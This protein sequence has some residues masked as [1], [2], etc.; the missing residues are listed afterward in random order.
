MPSLGTTRQ[1]RPGLP[2]DRE[3]VEQ[4]VVEWYVDSEAATE[5]YRNEPEFMARLLERGAIRHAV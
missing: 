3:A 4:L 2:G 1:P 5:C